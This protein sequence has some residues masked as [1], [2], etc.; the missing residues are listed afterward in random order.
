VAKKKKISLKEAGRL[1]QK[2]HD[3]ELRQ[4]AKEARDLHKKAEKS[5]ESLFELGKLLLR[6]RD[7]G[8]PR[9]LKA[10]I[11]EN[12]G[13]DIST[14]NRCN[15]AKSLAD[16]NSK[17]NKKRGSEPKNAVKVNWYELRD[18]RKEITLLMNSVVIGNVK[19]AVTCRR[20]IM[21]AVDAMVK[22]TEYFAFKWARKEHAKNL[23]KSG[24]PIGEKILATE[25]DE[26]EFYPAQM[27]REERARGYEK[28]P[29][30]DF[31]GRQQ[32]EIAEKAKE[33]TA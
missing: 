14:R 31:T 19:E 20:I 33:A 7:Y 28:E 22:R 21:G 15:Y 24:N 11:E 8:P 12:I 2:K 9:G 18:I 13:K 5:E 17:R 30:L 1:A 26:N 6:V 32:A 3:D 23:K 29:E 16:P 4:L 27:P 10:W 25:F